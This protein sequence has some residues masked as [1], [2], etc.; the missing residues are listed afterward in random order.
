[1]D[2]EAVKTM[3]ALAQQQGYQD[4]QEDFLQLLATDSKALGTMYGLAQDKGYA[5]DLLSF[6]ELMGLKKKEEPV[7]TESVSD[8]GSSEQRLASRD[9]EAERMSAFGAAGGGRVVDSREVPQEGYKSPAEVAKRDSAKTVIN[10]REA[11]IAAAQFS[12]R[13]E[14]AQRITSD[15]PPVTIPEGDVTSA[16]QELQQLYGP[17]GLRFS[18]EKVPAAMSRSGS[19]VVKATV[20]RGAGGKP[21]EV[22]LELDEN[23]NINPSE[24]AKVDTLLRENARYVGETDESFV[25]KAIAVQNLRSVPRIDSSGRSTV[26]MASAEVDGKFIAYPT[27]FPKDPAGTDSTNP[28]DWME[29]DFGVEA[30]DE[31][32]KRGEVFYFD[33]EEEAR[34]FG[35]GAWKGVVPMDLEFQKRHKEVGRDYDSDMAFLDELVERRDEYRFIEDLPVPGARYEEGLIPASYQKYFVDGNMVRDDI[36]TM[37]DEKE[38]ELS[39][40]ESQFDEDNVLLR[41]KEDRDVA[42]GKRYEQLSTEAAEINTE[43]KAQQNQLQAQSLRRFGVRLEDLATY[44]PKTEEELRGMI[45]LYNDYNQATSQRQ[46][47]ALG[48]E[49]AQTYYDRQ[50]DKGITEEYV[51]GW[52]EV[53]VAWD[54]GWKRG[55]AMS[56]LLLMQF[57]YYDVM[58]D[59]GAEERA[60][61]EVSEIMDSQDPRR[62]R[63]VSRANMTGTTDSYLASI[64]SNPGMYTAAITAE[65]LGQLI[66]IWKKVL[67]VA[68]VGGAVVGG[69][70]AGPG[71]SVL[72]TLGAIGTT[73]AQSAFM[74]GMPIS[75]LALEMGNA[76]LEV[77]ERMGYDWSDP[78]SALKALNDEKLWEDA[79]QRGLERGIPIATMGVLSNFFIG[80]A[81]G[82]SASIAS[83]GERIARGVGTGLIAEPAT[84][85]LGE[86]MAI[87][88]TGEYTGST[89]N[90]REIMAEAIGAVGMGASMGAAFG[91][92]GYAKQKLNESNF[93]LAMKLLDPMGIAREDVRG[94]RIVSWANKM[95][96]LGKITPEQ[97][98]GIRKNVGRRRQANELL[99]KNIDSRPGSDSKV[100]GRIVELLEAKEELER[101]G[102]NVFGEKIRAITEEIALIAETGK[103]E[104]PGGAAVNLSDI[105]GR[106]RNRRPGVYRFNGKNVSR[107]DFRAKLQ[108]A[109]PRQLKRARAYND[110]EV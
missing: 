24:A 3:Y 29:L 47:A 61:R 2:E 80:A 57:G 39:M 45:G 36:E 54:N 74:I 52:E 48:Y 101:S 55:E 11:N 96:K 5:D 78:N 105:R 40:L 75:E 110:V 62:G 79:K 68:A 13:Q 97:A 15:L 26:K 99:G 10:T 107:Q 85:A 82:R 16:L 92:L 35:E 25:E 30:Q 46:A 83:T 32:F 59:E 104:S 84:E 4:S 81:V 20:P 69:A 95:E 1:M 14:E 65:S 88:T 93:D 21:V 90:F 18:E 31:A 64:A 19:K 53:G 77:G 44:E 17:Y 106:I 86:Y 100:I 109:T 87:Q 58:G 72:G 103:V 42:L 8:G 67:P 89:A 108:E 70:T 98:E 6:E 34:A 63:I 50:Y 23:G 12:Q 91:T 28:D 66:P 102:P 56:K 27:L 43:A 37:R 71:G 7:V 22:R 41:L 51:D 60:M 49:R 73:A 33:T 94:E 9:L 76:T 38:A